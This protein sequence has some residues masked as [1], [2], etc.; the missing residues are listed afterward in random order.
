MSGWDQL[1][2]AQRELRKSGVPL[3]VWVGLPYREGPSSWLVPVRIE[4]IRDAAPFEGTAHGS[5]SVEALIHGLETI[6]AVLDSWN[7]D[8][9][10]T[11]HGASG[12]GFPS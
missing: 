7:T 8:D 5:D 2:I 4:G 10:I 3:S 6:A 1:V 9:S 11:W 12:H